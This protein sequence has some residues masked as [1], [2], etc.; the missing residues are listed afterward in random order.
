MDDKIYFGTKVGKP[1]YASKKFEQVKYN[2]Y[3][4]GGLNRDSKL[5]FVKGKEVRKFLFGDKRKLKKQVGFDR[6]DGW[7][8]GYK[9]LHRMKLK[10]GMNVFIDERE[11]FGGE[12]SKSY[13]TH[14][15]L[16]LG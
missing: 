11:L 1:K 13:S 15:F 5:K 2:N 4:F 12:L 9:S 7:V 16:T 14:Q 10:S 8:P 3:K 6:R